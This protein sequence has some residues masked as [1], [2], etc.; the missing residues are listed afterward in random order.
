MIPA[1]L[2]LSEK[3]F[4]EKVQ[5][6]YS[7]LECCRLCPQ[8]CRIN[9]INGEKGFCNVGNKPYIS[10]YGAHFG[11]EPPITGF[12]GSGTIFFTYCNLKC[13]Y[14]QNYTIS[15]FGEGEEID[16]YRLREIM[17]YLKK[18]GCHNINLVT[19]THQIPFI[20][21]AIFK[22][23]REGL[24]IPIVYNCG[25]YESI[26]TLKLL[27]GVIDIY[28]PDIKYFDNQIAEK[29]SS[30]KNYVDIAKLALKEMH[31]QVG[32]LIVADGVAIRGL[33]V[34]HLILPDDIAGT[35][36]FVKFLSEEISSNTYLNIM[37]QYYPCYRAKEIDFLNRRITRDEFLKA[38]SMAKRAGLKRVF[39]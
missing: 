26:E 5:S 21:E 34:R 3:D 13:L 9:R 23:S 24:N 32:D 19:P 36:K 14:C 6:L 17:L 20:V 12:R 16:V 11:E 30:A 35:D 8:D 39:Y 33:I 2:N 10:S 4:K 25:G 31:R 28:M 1:Y 15:Q 38:V 29:L 37:D 22:A 7:L 27:E 18:L